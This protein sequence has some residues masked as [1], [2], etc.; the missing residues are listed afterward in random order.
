VADFLHNIAY[1]SGRA[2]L[3]LDACYQNNDGDL[4]GITQ[5]GF[6]AYSGLEGTTLAM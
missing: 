3:S 6:S 5:A 2:I 4:T 1:A